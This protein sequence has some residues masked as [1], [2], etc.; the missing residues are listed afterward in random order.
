M[1]SKNIYFEKNLKYLSLWL[2]FKSK[3]YFQF[4]KMIYIDNFFLIKISFY[5]K[6][7]LFNH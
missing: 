1:K 5:K 4:L 6:N 7:S 3:F 2:T